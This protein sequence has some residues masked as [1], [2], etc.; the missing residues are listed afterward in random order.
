MKLNII[1]GFVIRRLQ[2]GQTLTKWGELEESSFNWSVTDEIVDGS[3]RE[4]IL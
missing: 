2:I 3:K 4:G 1:R